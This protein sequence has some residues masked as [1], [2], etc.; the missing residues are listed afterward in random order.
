M[1]GDGARHPYTL[2]IKEADVVKIPA[3]TEPAGHRNWK[4]LAVQEISAASGRP[5][6][7]AIAWA[8]TMYL[9]EEEM[10]IAKLWNTHRRFRTLSTKL[11][12]AFLK[13]VKGELARRI[14]QLIEDSM[15]QNLSVPGLVIGRLISD[16]YRTTSQGEAM[17]SLNELQLSLIH[18]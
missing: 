16:W 6:D 14:Q 4:V 15:K 12:A 17:Y 13:V 9:S 3:L 8:R 18:I 10:P 7:K 11:A 2:K 5:D 1:A